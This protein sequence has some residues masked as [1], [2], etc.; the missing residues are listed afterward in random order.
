MF[1]KSI[2]EAKVLLSLLLVVDFVT[3]ANKDDLFN[4]KYIIR[5]SEQTLGI[6]IAVTDDSLSFFLC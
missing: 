6:Y 4:V 3:V 1:R 5:T 2:I